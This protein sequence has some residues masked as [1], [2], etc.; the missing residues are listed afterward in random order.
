MNIAEMITQIRS[1]MGISQTNLANRLRVSRFT[2]SRWERGERKPHKYLHREVVR[3][4]T[5]LQ[6]SLN[7]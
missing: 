1:Q 5:K 2:I 6:N 3:F 4:Y 7:D